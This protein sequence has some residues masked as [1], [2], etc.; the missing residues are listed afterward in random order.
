MAI[1]FAIDGGKALHMPAPPANAAD[2]FKKVL[3]DSIIIFRGQT[4][5]ESD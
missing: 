2:F 5:N 3:L 1:A 4:W